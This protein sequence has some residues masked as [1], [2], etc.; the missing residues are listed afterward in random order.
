M[1]QV[2][3]DLSGPPPRLQEELQYCLERLVRGLG[4]NRKGARQGFSIAL[5]EL[6]ATFPQVTGGQVLALAERHLQP[7]RSAKAEVRA[8]VRGSCNSVR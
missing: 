8:C 1:A 4:S 2:C 5:T 7:A 3:F 6:L